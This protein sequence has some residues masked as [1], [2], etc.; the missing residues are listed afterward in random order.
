[1]VDDKPH[2]LTLELSDLSFRAEMEGSKDDFLFAIR[3]GFEDDVLSPEKEI[4]LFEVSYPFTGFLLLL[5]AL[6]VLL[7]QS[8]LVELFERIN[9][10]LELHFQLGFDG[11][12]NV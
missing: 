8:S 12:V 5:R 10:L 7:L 9:I 2:E 3:K 4:F 11:I 6:L 1:M